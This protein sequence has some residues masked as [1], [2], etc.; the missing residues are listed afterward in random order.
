[1]T[2]ALFMYCA[3]MFPAALVR[4]NTSSLQQLGV[5]VIDIRDTDPTVQVVHMWHFGGIAWQIGSLVVL[6]DKIA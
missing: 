4:L 2:Y 6:A 3:G 1:M 5:H